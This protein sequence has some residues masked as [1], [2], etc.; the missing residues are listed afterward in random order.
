MRAFI[1]DLDGT[2]FD[3]MG[4]WADIDIAFLEKRGIP[5][6]DDYT[7]TV[8][9]L[10]FHEAAAYTI[11]RFSLACSVDDLI[12]E[13]NNMAVSAYQSTVQLKPYAKEYLLALSSLGLPL[14]I[15][16]SS[17]P[18]LYVPALCNH[19]I[20]DLFSVICNA[21]EVG[22]GK[23]EPD[24]F[25]LTA[26]K[27]G[28]SPCDCVLFEDILPAVKSAKSIGMTVHGVYDKSSDADW[29]QIKKIADGAILDFQNAPL[30]KR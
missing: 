21:S 3:S 13:W 17:V 4:V 20:Y 23:S 22:C 28:V 2:L 14:A 12:R 1:F 26:Q 29:E 27:L 7:D 16:T 11:E 5:V 30:P 15:A 6:P 9:S 24:I 18:E 10:S 19:G 8:L 25:L